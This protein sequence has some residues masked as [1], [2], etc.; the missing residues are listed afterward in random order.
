MDE[1]LRAT[2]LWLPGMIA[3]LC[4][5]A[6][7]GFCSAS[8]TALFYLSHDELRS[9]RIG[10]ARER[11]AAALLSEPDRL[12][13]ALLFWN[14]MVNLAY[15]AVGVVVTHR[16][17]VAG[18][19]AAAGVY[20]LVTLVAMILF[21][22]VLP[23]SL[24]VAFRRPLASWAG[25]PLAVAV[26]LL[27]PV[28]PVLMRTTRRLRRTFW[29]HL[30]REPALDVDDLERAIEASELSEEV[31]RQER[32]VLRNILDLAGITVEEVMRPRGTYVALTPPIHLEDLNR[33]VPPGGYVL[34]QNEEGEAID[35]AIPLI[36][37]ARI[38]QKHL[39][40]VA[41]Q[42]VHVPW[43]ATVGSAL[44]QMR[45]RIC[46]VAEVVNE[47]G[48]T[49]GIVTYEDVI[50]MVLI[51]PS[52]AKQLLK[53]EPVVEISPGRFHVEGLTTLRHLCKRLGLEFEPHADGLITVAGMLHEDLERMPAVGDE[54]AWRGFRMQVIETA[55]RGTLRVLVERRVS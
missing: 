30:A 53:R 32:L 3:M 9:L 26:R 19:A 8:E 54:A 49:I 51:A 14:L 42:V 23:K 24:A 4:L 17:S 22:E 36:D 46:S 20:G 7:S 6:A 11:A 44:Q 40:R 25:W 27:D 2:H 50:E 38:P 15:F 28:T 16:L 34:L 21:G 1:F 18:L 37:F 12:L 55:G 45:D 41:E 52:R 29:P 31:V 13:T 43:C 48:E 39:E 10:N 35:G 33:E 5:V 47:Y